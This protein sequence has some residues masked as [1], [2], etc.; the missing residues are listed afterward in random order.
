[1]SLEMNK[2]IA[3]R[4]FEELANAGNLA[5]APEILP[6]EAVEVM[7]QFTVML[8][9]AFPDFQV[10]IED[11]IAEGDRVATRFTARGTH[12]GKWRSP[13][14]VMPPTGKQFEHE[15]VRIFRIADGKL[16]DTW[17]GADT[18]KQLQ[19]LGII[20]TEIISK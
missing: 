15:G 14:G 4:Y 8:R 19:Q 16:A 11:Q 13:V 12:L 17:G 10:A 18:L 9:T 7:Q 6:P 1:M 3:R 2:A 20:P 5:V